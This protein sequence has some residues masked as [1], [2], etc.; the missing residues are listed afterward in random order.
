[1]RDRAA[2]SEKETR[3]NVS[4]ILLSQGRLREQVQTLEQRLKQRG[5]IG[6]DSTME[7][8]AAELPQAVAAMKEAEERLAA[9][10][11]ERCAAARAEGACSIFSER[12][13]RIAKC[14]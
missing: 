1:M 14:R 12:R 5:V 10:R 8:I 9:E 6:A 11:G 3:E 4:T 7:K 2:T 13:Q